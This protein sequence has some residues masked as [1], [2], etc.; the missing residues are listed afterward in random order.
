MTQELAPLSDEIENWL[1]ENS[2]D[3]A[4][5]E[6]WRKYYHCWGQS[7][8]HL[9]ANGIIQTPAGLMIHARGEEEARLKQ[10]RL[11]ERESRN[12]KRART[13]AQANNSS[14]WVEWHKLCSERKQKIE[15][16][17][18]EWRKRIAERKASDLQWDAYVEQS[19][20]AYHELKS[21]PIPERPSSAS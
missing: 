21:S 10:S 6:M 19:R 11:E 3:D 14:A 16:A 8:P 2:V 7:S 5:R 1:T 13:E 20:A 18:K 17:N 15:E 4:T 12:R 9:E